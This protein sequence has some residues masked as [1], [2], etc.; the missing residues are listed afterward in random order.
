MYSRKK[1]RFAQLL[2]KRAKMSKI[3]GEKNEES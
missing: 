3:A 2:K 1:G